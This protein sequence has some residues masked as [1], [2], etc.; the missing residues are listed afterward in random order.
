ML[1]NS[2]DSGKQSLQTS[3]C[4]RL[5]AHRKGSQEEKS[6]SEGSLGLNRCL[7]S[8]IG[9]KSLNR[10]NIKLNWNIIYPGIIKQWPWRNWASER[11][12]C[13]PVAIYS[14]CKWATS[15]RIVLYLGKLQGPQVGLLG[16]VSGNRG[17]SK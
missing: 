2:S 1:C 16:Q 12:P 6:H 5:S 10:F 7:N 3:Y 17:P 13:S 15:S 14:S 11:A 8:I 4:L 9:A